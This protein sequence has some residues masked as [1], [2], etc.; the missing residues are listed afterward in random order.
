MNRWAACSTTESTELSNGLVISQAYKIG[1][2]KTKTNYVINGYQDNG[3]SV[4]NN[5]TWVAV[6]GGACGSMLADAVAVLGRLDVERDDVRAG[7]SE[8]L[9]LRLGMLDH[10]VDIEDALRCLA[11]ALDDRRAQR[12]VR[13]VCAVH[14]IDVDVIRAS[15]LDA[16]DLIGQEIGRAHV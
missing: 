10:Q 4:V 13:H 7:L 3:S 2:S 12:D 6:G 9:D 5:T 1:Q 8:G 15:I 14:D 16:L 11:Q